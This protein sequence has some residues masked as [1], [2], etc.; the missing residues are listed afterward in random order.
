MRGTKWLL[1]IV[2]LLA[3]G[4]FLTGCGGK[5]TEPTSKPQ[6]EQPAAEPAAKEQPAEKP[7]EDKPAEDKPAAEEPAANNPAADNAA[8]E[9]PD[10]EEPA[11]A[12]PAKQP[13]DHTTFGDDCIGCHG[14]NLP[15]GHAQENCA[16]CHPPSN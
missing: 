10:E 7:A 8:K 11:P 16:G 6:A 2:V 15:T 14:A 13:A 5:K 1:I 4:L 12:G 9:E 3:A